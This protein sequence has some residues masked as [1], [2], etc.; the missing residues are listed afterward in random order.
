MIIHPLSPDLSPMELLCKFKTMPLAD[1]GRPLF[2][3]IIDVGEIFANLALVTAQGFGFD[4]E[5]LAYIYPVIGII[6][7]PVP[8][9]LDL[10]GFLSLSE[11]IRVSEIV[12][13]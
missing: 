12:A 11:K 13:S 5:G 2:Y 4:L 6:R 10:M 3:P 7:P 1:I 9:F 8:D